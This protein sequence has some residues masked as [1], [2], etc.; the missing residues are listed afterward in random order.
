MHATPPRGS[1]AGPPA[2]AL[3][4]CV[5]AFCL[6]AC[7]PLCSGVRSVSCLLVWCVAFRPHGTELFTPEEAAKNVGKAGQEEL[8]LSRW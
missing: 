5:S 7:L 3:C 4:L 6:P 2:S 8:V 1:D